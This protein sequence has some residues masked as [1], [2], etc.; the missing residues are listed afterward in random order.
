MELMDDSTHF[1]LNS[2]KV[3]PSTRLS[4]L[5]PLKIEVEGR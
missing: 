3:M 1:M 2:G 4:S 5:S